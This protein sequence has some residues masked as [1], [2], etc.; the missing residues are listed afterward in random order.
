[1]KKRRQKRNKKKLGVISVFAIVI[2]MV[3]LFSLLLKLKPHSENTAKP[4]VTST[5]KTTSSSSKAVVKPKTPSMPEL[6]LEQQ[7][8][9]LIMVGMTANDYE[10]AS[11]DAIKTYQV[12]N[13]ILTGRSYLDIATTKEITT[14]L[15]SL[16][17][18]NLQ[19][20]IAC[21]QEGGNVQVLQGQGFSAIPDGLTQG[22]WSPEQLQK[23]AQIWGSQLAQAGVNFDL[24]PVADSVPSAEFAPQN[25]PIGY[26]HREY[27]YT[28]DGIVS[29]ANAF[30]KGMSA[31]NVLTTIK[32]FPS[33]GSVTGNTDTTAQV[34]DTQTTADGSSVDVFKRLIAD[35]VLSVMTATAIY[36]QIDPSLPGAFSSKMVQG[37]LRDKLG[38]DGLVITDDLS[39]A[40]QVQAWSPGER[41]LL[42]IGAGNDIVLAG[43]PTQIPE[44]VSALLTKAKS[45]SSFADKIHQAAD[46]VV[47][48]KQKMKL[49][50]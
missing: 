10:Q 27:G 22:T 48:T 33:L 5:E 13:V 46:R 19:L 29:H 4:S 12:G 36:Q 9:Q 11:L 18:K 26:W 42:A 37:L 39:N 20:L 44:M 21:D 30:S 6:T 1:M 49:A 31:A 41:A 40:A 32:H 2:F 8:G 50:E 34:T 7:V 3:S 16:A 38:F 45:D 23:S 35:G 17:P 14:Q 25:A 43:N 47:K 24:A 15:Q 28:A